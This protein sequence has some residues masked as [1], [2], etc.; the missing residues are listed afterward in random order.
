MI[1]M[2]FLMALLVLS[3][4]CGPGWLLSREGPTTHSESLPAEGESGI[5]VPSEAAIEVEA[6]PA[7]RCG[8]ACLHIAKISVSEVEREG[9]KNWLDACD[10]RCEE[11]GSS[12]QLDCYERSQSPEDLA[13]CMTR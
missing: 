1:R 5:E 4:G 2:F 3:S 11:H 10:A 8:R 12:G 9:R 6:E 13:S 7:T